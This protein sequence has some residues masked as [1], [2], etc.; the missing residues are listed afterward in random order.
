[1]S[2]LDLPG[3]DASASTALLR[4]KAGQQR[5]AP[6]GLRR[7]ATH[8]VSARAAGEHWRWTARFDLAVGVSLVSVHVLEFGREL[9]PHQSPRARAPRD[10]LS[11]ASR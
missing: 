2:P 6:G 11:R 4:G 8:Q 1:M 5:A 3:A 9:D 10:R 7:G